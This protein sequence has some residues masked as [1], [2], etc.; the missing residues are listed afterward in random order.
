MPRK[1]RENILKV[2]I[3]EG[4]PSII[5]HLYKVGSQSQ[6]VQ[7]GH[8]DIP[9]PSDTLQLLLGG[10]EAFPG[11]MGY[12]IQPASDPGLFPTGTAWKYL[13]FGANS[14]LGCD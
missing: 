8:P 3:S 7:E 6:R 14:G 9:L 2:D 10:P 11:Q 4:H 5:C 1:A 13:C 12:I